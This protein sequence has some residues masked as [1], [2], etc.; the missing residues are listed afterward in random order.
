ML[1]SW[2]PGRVVGSP[3]TLR[4]ASQVLVTVLGTCMAMQHRVV[5]K[6]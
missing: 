1:V 5:V 3:D 4:F 2:G 6:L